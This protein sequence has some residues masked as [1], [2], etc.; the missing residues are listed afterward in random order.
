MENC[1]FCKIASGEIPGMRVYEDEHTL[2]IMDIA[3]DVD[4]HILVIPKIHVK[5]ILDC[6]NETLCEVMKTVKKVGNHL[7]DHCGYDG[8][9][10]LCANDESA[11]QS[12][13]HFHVHIIPRKYG[14]GLGGNA[15]W[16]SFPGAKHD[17]EETFKKLRI[18]S[19][20]SATSDC[21]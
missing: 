17:L 1:I 9:D 15:E 11:G 6:D 16:P 19:D 7:T 2:A 4:G 21:P 13:N 5:N 18:K 20:F 8:L 3:K 10:L 14:D 12:V